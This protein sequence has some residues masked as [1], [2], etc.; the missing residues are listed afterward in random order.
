MRPLRLKSQGIG[1]AQSLCMQLERALPPAVLEHKFHSTRRWRFDV[2]WPQL[3]LAVEIEGGAYIAGRHMRGPG[4]E[5][6]IEKY[7]EAMCLGWRILRVMP[8]QVR[9]GTAAAWVR[10]IAAGDG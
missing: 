2:S 7:A 1:V 4:F 10:R 8:D 3:K 6:D 5:A 9:D